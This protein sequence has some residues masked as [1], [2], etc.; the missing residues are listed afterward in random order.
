[1]FVDDQ[2]N[3]WL[4]NTPASRV[5]ALDLAGNV[6]LEFPVAPGVPAQP[7]DIAV[8]PDG[9]IY[10]TDVI[11]DK[12]LCFG[13][14]GQQL[15]SWLIPHSTSVDGAHLAVAATGGLYLTVPEEGRVLHLDSNGETVASWD[16]RQPDG[17]LMKPVGLAVDAAG[18]VWVVDSAGGNIVVLTVTE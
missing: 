7:V 3:V 17:R 15:Q 18:R 16:L 12:L 8:T 13:P 9:N 10:V 14:A 2:N 1:L 4:A 6:V 11:L 5:A